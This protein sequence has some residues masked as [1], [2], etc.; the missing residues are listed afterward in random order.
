MGTMI[1]KVFEDYFSVASEA[2]LEMQRQ[3]GENVFSEDGIM[4]KGLIIR[5]LVLPGNVSQAM[6][7]MDWV[8]ENLPEG[9]VLSLMSQ[10]TP[11]GKASEYP[12]INRKLSE[13]EYD[14]VLDYAD[15]LGLENVFI[16]ET[17]SSSTDFIPAFDL[18][19]V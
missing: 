5:H 9:T 18:S 3:I 4:Q 13:R 7:V 11:C 15:K 17:G 12:T 1:F 2:V 6:R 8:K 10:Y 16:Q 19:G 14:M